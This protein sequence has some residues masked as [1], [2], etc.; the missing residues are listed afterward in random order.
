MDDGFTTFAEVGPG[1]VL[2]GLMRE[3]A[4]HATVYNV[5]NTGTLSKF[6]AS[7]KAHTA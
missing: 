7:E 6:L 3:I 5:E 1:K 2:K 4:T